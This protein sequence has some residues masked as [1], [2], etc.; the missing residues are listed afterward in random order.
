MDA[1]EW[2][3][4]A[5]DTLVTVVFYANDT[6]GNI[7]Q[8]EV[9]V[10]KSGP[11]TNGDTPGELVPGYDLLILMVGMFVISISSFYKRKKR[12]G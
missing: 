3:D 9:M 6:A 4:F 10:R 12:L 8:A 2:A 5:N 11:P 1:L 7:G